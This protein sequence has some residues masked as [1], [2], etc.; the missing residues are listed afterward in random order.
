MDAYVWCSQILMNV[1][2]LMTFVLRMQRVQTLL[3][4]TIAP[5]IQALSETALSV[6]RHISVEHYI[7]IRGL[8]WNT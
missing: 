4:A 7:T 5:V 6:V 2:R 8:K 1:L 3:V